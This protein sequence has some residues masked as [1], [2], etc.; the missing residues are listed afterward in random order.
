MVTCEGCKYL[1]TYPSPAVFLH[2][3]RIG[4]ESTERRTPG[5]AVG[6][7]YWTAPYSIAHP[8]SLLPSVP[9]AIGLQAAWGFH[10]WLGDITA[11]LPSGLCPI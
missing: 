1:Q 8:Y 7:S 4:F 9:P 3:P 11:A 10:W 2:A 6:A 5:I